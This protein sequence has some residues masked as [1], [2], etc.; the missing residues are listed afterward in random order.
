MGD[1]NAANVGKADSIVL[2]S[3]ECI[4]HKDEKVQW[5]QLLRAE[6]DDSEMMEEFICKICQVHVVGCEPKLARCSHIFCGD[7]IATW[8][9]VQPRSQSWAQR[10]QSAGLVP[11]PVCKEP[12]HEENDLFTVC[13]EGQNESALLWRLLSG[14][15]IVCGNNPKCRKDGK[16]NW[17]G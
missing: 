10:A 17:T 1:A 13:P 16:C 9:A 15:K 5:D 8:F 7:C 14:V 4:Q 3:E 2:K 6:G 11:C 12:L